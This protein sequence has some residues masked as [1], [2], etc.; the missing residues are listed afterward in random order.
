MAKRVVAVIQ[1]RMGSTRLPGKAL[2][3]ILDR[4][5]VEWVHYRLSFAKEVDEVVLATADTKENDELAEYA[6]SVG[7][8]VFR[9]SEVDLLS[10][11][12][13]VA[14]EYDADAVVRVCA[15]C[16]LVDSQI[17]DRLVRAYK[18]DDSVEFVCNNMPPTFAHGMDVEVIPTRT[19][20][21][22][23]D[24]ITDELY[25]EWLTMPIVENRD[26]FVVRNI[27]DDGDRRDYR[28]TVDYPEDLELIEKIYEKLHVEGKVFFLDDVIG[29]LEREPAL[30]EI[31]AR[32]L[33]SEVKDDVR[34][35]D[36][37]QNLK[38]GK[39]S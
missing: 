25:R 34:R 15:D 31:N 22:L 20:D 39:E 36:E 4:S 17:V 24:E 2:K 38:H 6:R 16:P 33:K 32:W 29:L 26:K 5:L 23:H 18:E 28:L 11:Y 9:G 37:F 3:R 12:R 13:G 35:N 14:K 21:R 30:R 8:K 10:R 1:A 7:I 19:L 27:S